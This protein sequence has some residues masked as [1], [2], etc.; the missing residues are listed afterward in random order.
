MLY[1]AKIGQ[2]LD[3]SRWIVAIQNR[4][5]KKCVTIACFAYKAECVRWAED[6][7]RRKAWRDGSELPDMHDKQE[8][9]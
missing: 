5:T 9:K 1:R 2:D 6:T 8:S 7:I 3:K 4:F